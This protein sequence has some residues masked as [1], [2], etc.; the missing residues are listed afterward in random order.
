MTP[1]AAGSR[2]AG[3]GRPRA[4]PRVTSARQAG[5]DL[6]ARIEE[7]QAAIR[8]RLDSRDA[9][10][11]VVV[12]TNTTLD[13][14]RLAEFLIGWAPGWWPLTTWAVIAL[15][16]EEQLSILAERGLAAG[17]ASTVQAVAGWVMHSGEIFAGGDL[18][19]DQ[20]LPGPLAGVSAVGFPL[21]GRSRAVGAMVGL[22]RRPSRPPVISRRVAAS[23]H[24]L[25]QP[26]GVA[27][28]NAM[29]IERAEALSVTDED[30]KSVV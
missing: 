15:D 4:V 28:E 5:P 17:L 3:R 12:S 21:H 26:A 2:S 1:P 30:R 13:P 22:D 11:E 18:R 27:L 7:R 14:Q 6:A 25:L 9:L 24:D 16:A 23:W 10:A 20:R 29:L 8:R 19:S